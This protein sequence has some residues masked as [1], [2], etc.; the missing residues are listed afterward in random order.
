MTQ[1]PPGD[2]CKAILRAS[3]KTIILS[4]VIFFWFEVGKNP[5]FP[6]NKVHEFVVMLLKPNNV[7]RRV[8]LKLKLKKEK[9]P[10][11]LVSDET[12]YFSSIRFMLTK[13]QGR[14]GAAAWVVWG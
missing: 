11:S 12:D 8:T 10:K 9:C 6:K 3:D 1:V 13:L 14:G 5:Q 4:L 2:K 7:L